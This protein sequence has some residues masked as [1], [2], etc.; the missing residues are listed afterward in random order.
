M[1]K[2]ARE[3]GEVLVSFQGGRFHFYKNYIASDENE[4]YSHDPEQISNLL[5]DKKKVYKHKKTWNKFIKG[6]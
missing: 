2:K 5:S 3:Y 6:D 4:V 1:A